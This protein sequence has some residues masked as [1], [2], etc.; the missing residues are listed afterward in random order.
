MW[1]L[2]CTSE[3][4]TGVHPINPLCHLLSSFAVRWG[5]MMKP[6]W[7]SNRS[8]TP[9][10]ERVGNRR[11]SSQWVFVSA[12][13][14]LGWIPWCLR[15]QRSLCSA[16]TGTGFNTF[17]VQDHIWIMKLL[18]AVLCHSG[19]FAAWAAL[20]KSLLVNA[21]SLTWSY[22]VL[23]AAYFHRFWFWFDFLVMH[24]HDQP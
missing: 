6:G 20:W 21:C 12:I 2:N 16:T 10:W 19:L 22:T 5:S 1:M 17:S 3:S 18:K 23:H 11:K 8:T 4:E 7:S 15:K 13:H 9:T 14:C 24:I